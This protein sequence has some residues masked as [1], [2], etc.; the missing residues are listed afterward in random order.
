MKPPLCQCGARAQYS[1]CVLVSSLGVRPRRQKCGIAHTF[2]AA[3]IRQLLCERWSMAASGVRESL[4]QAYTAIADRLK[5]ES[6]RLVAS[7]CAED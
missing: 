6:E 5:A 2:C 3:C 7:K 4:S 1:V